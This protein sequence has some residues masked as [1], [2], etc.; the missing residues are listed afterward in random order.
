MENIASYHI[1]NY[2][3]L[4]GFWRINTFCI[5]LHDWSYIPFSYNQTL[6]KSGQWTNY[7]TKNGNG[8]KTFSIRPTCF[9]ISICWTKGN[10]TCWNKG[11]K[12]ALSSTKPNCGIF[13]G[14][15]QHQKGYLVFIP[16]TRKIVSSYE[17]IFDETCSIGLAYTARPYSEAL[18]MRLVVL[19]ITYATSF[20]EQTGNIIIFGQFKEG[21]L[22]EN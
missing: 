15:P 10:C 20:H 22:L 4:T 18:A 5:N 1:F 19:Y 16:S 7:A 8:H 13:V 3:S 6:G 21:Y 14:I 2:S 12:H 9:I 17:I 11:F